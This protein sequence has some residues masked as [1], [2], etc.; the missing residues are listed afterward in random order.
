MRTKR[1]KSERKV[2]P[3]WILLSAAAL[4][5]F[6]L[7]AGFQLCDSLGMALTWPDQSQ[8][9]L[10]SRYLSPVALKLSLD[11][12]RLYVVCESSDQVLVLDTGAQRVVARIEVGHKPKGIAASPDGKTLYVSNEWDGTV[13]EID[14]ESFQVRRTIHVGWGPVGITT[15]PA[16]KF[17]YVANTLG[18]NISVIELS[19][20]QEIK[21]L[22]AGHFPEYVALARDG[23][24]IFVSN[25]L[26]RVEP[27]NKPPLSQ[28][29]VI[30][31]QRQVVSER[32]D[33]P[34]VIQLRHIAELP[35][36]DG[37]YLLIPFMRPKNLNP[38]IQVQQGWYLTHGIAL[39]QPSDDGAVRERKSSVAEVLLDD[40]DNYYADGFGAASTPDG[41]WALVTASGANIVSII[42]TAKLAQLRQR[43]PRGEPEALADRLDSARQFVVRRLPT[44]RNPTDVVVSPN[45]RFAYIANRTD[46]TVSVVNMQ[47]LKI[48]STIELGG[49]KKITRIRRGEQV[50]FDA[51][52]CF[53]GQMACATCHPHEGLSDGL[54]WSLETPRLGRDVV[55]N[56]TLLAIGETSPFKWNGKNLD[57]ATQ[58]GPRTAMYI[59][60]SQGFSPNDLK[61]LVTY[62][63][64]LQIPPN[65]RLAQHGGLTESQARGRAIF[66]RTKTNAGAVI[67]ARD[68]CY[69]CHAPLTH[70]TS[71]VRMDVGT[72]TEY[73]TIK[74][75]DIPQLDGV[76][77]RPP[78]LH[79]G[80]ALTLEEIWTKF[81]PKDQ[82][83][84]TSDMDKVQLNDLI[85]Y[86]KT[87]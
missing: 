87:L 57:L 53:Q 14:S 46:D 40:V 39:I 69:F 72:A 31:T 5:F 47:E 60:R 7:W 50:F 15:D 78:F 48:A 20:G 35:R 83:G 59:F 19:K 75:F 84:I 38:L 13:N 58:D 33:V 56:R 52:T 71:R 77:M 28:L 24:R 3:R 79:N 1:R 36:R 18:N 23:K 55:E 76:Y 68:R 51:S 81:N 8:D 54:A 27:Y 73:D 70:Y 25:L 16:G 30:D 86:L 32:I 34:G 65:P 85:E 12:Q 66:F 9:D 21:R 43:A 2:S 26:V 67:P 64:S 29:T 63:E 45:G 74:E 41:R 10:D 82:H 37:G 4:L 6:A 80:E 42:D 44:G 17:L 49:P 22:E 62:M 61:D 11:G